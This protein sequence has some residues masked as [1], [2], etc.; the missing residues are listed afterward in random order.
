MDIKN[1]FSDAISRIGLQLPD[2]SFDLL[3]EHY[4]LLKKWNSTFNLTSL[5]NPEDIIDRLYIDSLLFH[6]GIPEDSP[7]IFDF[8]SGPGFPGVPLLLMRPQLR[9]TLVEPKQRMTSFLSEV[10]HAFYGQI[11]F[12]INQSRCDSPEFIDK[13]GKQVSIAVSKGFAPPDRALQLLLPL[14]ATDGVYVTCTNVDTPISTPL[15]GPIILEDEHTY[16]LP[17][18]GRTTRHLIFRHTNL[19]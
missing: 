17:L 4:L 13:H 7:V 19:I 15:E 11:S 3:I 16:T 1:I 5:L 2:S 18:T 6:N 8:G 14:L 9:L 10:K 12:D